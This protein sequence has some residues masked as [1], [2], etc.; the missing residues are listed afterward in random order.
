MELATLNSRLSTSF[1][2]SLLTAH[3][4]LIGTAVALFTGYAVSELRQH[5]SGDSAALLPALLSA[6]AAAA[7]TVY[8]RW[9]WI[10]RPGAPRE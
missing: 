7:L 6:L 1:K 2:M 9:V 10:R 4:I 5:L 3:K 8:L